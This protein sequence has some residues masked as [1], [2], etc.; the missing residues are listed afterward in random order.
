MV[1]PRLSC[2]RKGAVLSSVGEGSL[3]D[4]DSGPCSNR[5]GTAPVTVTNIPLFYTYLTFTMMITK[6][7]PALMPRPQLKRRFVYQCIAIVFMFRTGVRCAR[8][9]RYIY[10]KNTDHQISYRDY[11]DKRIEFSVLLLD[12][13]F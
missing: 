7:W 1:L 11:P 2:C 6:T 10:K 8:L 13:L 9:T 5:S 3:E 4:P 12:L